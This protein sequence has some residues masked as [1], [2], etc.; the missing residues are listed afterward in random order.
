MKQEETNNKYV[1]LTRNKYLAM[2]VLMIFMAFLS[3]GF[4]VAVT[5]ITMK[6]EEEISISEKYRK[7]QSD[8]K[9][10]NSRVKKCENTIS[11]LNE[12]VNE[13]DKQ[14]KN[15]VKLNE[16]YY[17]AIQTFEQREEL[18]DKYEYAIIRSDEGTRTDITYGHLIDLEE[19]AKEKKIDTDLILSIVMVESDGNEKET[20]NESTARGFGQ[21]LIGTGEFTYENLMKAGSYDHSY[22]L[23]GKT[24][25]T[26]MVYYIDWLR[27]IHDGNIY[28]MIKNY[29]GEDGAILEDYISRIN[30]Y[31]S[32]KG[33]S[34]YSLDQ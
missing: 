2:K 8:Y 34:V 24:N 5:T 29:R 7:V 19:I 31:L 21:F 20:S 33:K 32:L 25:L 30:K 9:K 4:I 15:L 13:L 1:V 23:N 27:K 10:L 11:K 28:K 16:E 3:M 26:M 22:A 6:H 12:V 18:F 17:E 14:A